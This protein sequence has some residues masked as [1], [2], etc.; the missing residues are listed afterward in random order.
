MD[1]GTV[2]KKLTGPH[3]SLSRESIEN[4]SFWAGLLALSSIPLDGGNGHGI[5]EG[6]VK[7]GRKLGREGKGSS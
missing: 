5:A 4:C 1:P 7:P 3:S 6:A 2:P